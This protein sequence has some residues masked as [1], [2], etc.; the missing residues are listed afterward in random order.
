MALITKAE[1]SRSQQSDQKVTKNSCHHQH[2][3]FFEYY[4]NAQGAYDAEQT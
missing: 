3:S 4:S 1:A 2:T